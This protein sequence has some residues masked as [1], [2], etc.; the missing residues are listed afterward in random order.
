MYYV[1]YT[2]Y[3]LNDSLKVAFFYIHLLNKVKK[4]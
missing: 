3:I 4:E 2:Y 1:C